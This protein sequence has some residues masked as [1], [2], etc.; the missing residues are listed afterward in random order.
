[1]DLTTLDEVKCLLEDDTT[2]FDTILQSYITSVSARVQ[3]FCNRNFERQ[4]YIEIH[5]GG[6]HRIYVDNPPISSVTS[7][8]WDDFFDFVNGFNFPTQDFAIVNRGWEIAY[9]SGDWPGGRD[10]LQVTYDG[11][12][13]PPD[14]PTSTLP[15]DLQQAVAQQVIFEFKHR[16][17]FGLRDVDFPDGRL[18]K[19]AD[20]DFILPV[21]QVLRLHRVPQVG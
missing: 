2:N 3:A 12:F 9:V 7:I 13:L 1:M 11:G 16:K 4:T 14:D 20:Q 21:R 19:V 15:K 6:T 5:D 8:I 10:A 18:E 17:D